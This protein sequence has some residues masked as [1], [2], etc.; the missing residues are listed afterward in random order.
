CARPSSGE[1]FAYW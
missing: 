1:W